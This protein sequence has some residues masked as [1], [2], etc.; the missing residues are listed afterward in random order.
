MKRLPYWLCIFGVSIAD[1]IILNAFP[2]TWLVVLIPSM[3]LTGWICGKRAG[4]AGKNVRFWV[5]IGLLVPFGAFV[6]GCF[7]SE[8]DPM[9]SRFAAAE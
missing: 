2:Q 5:A 7:R 1:D 6:L 4:D 9:I 8:G 3:I